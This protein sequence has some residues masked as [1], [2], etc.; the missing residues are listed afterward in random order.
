M[1]KNESFFVIENER[2]QY[3]IGSGVNYDGRVYAYS[4]FFDDL[5]MGQVLWDLIPVQHEGEE[6]YEIRDSLHGKYLVAGYEYDGN[7][8]HQDRHGHLNGLWRIDS[9][10]RQEDNVEIYVI[11]DL[12]HGKSLTAPAD[13]SHLLI[14]GNLISRDNYV[15]H[16]DYNGSKLAEWLIYTGVG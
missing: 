15:Y 6:V 4:G 14:G 12:R 16:Y 5:W 8:Y 2:T 11:T 1:E 10:I 9:R 7:I 13:V 3:V